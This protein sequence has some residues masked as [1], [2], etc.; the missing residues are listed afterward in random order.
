MV[1][2]DQAAFQKVYGSHQ[3]VAGNFA[4]GTALGNGGDRIKLEDAHNGTILDF[5]FDDD[6]PWPEL[7]DGNGFSLV[8]ISPETHPDPTNAAS[9][10][11]SSSKGGSPGS[12]DDSVFAGDP[13]A[14]LDG[15]GEFDLEDFAYGND[16]DRPQLR[17]VFRWESGVN[18]AEDH[19][20]LII[21]FNPM[22]E[23]YIIDP[24]FSSDLQSW[25]RG[26]DQLEKV[27]NE[28]LDDGR[29]LQI[30]KVNAPLRDQ[31]QLFMQLRITQP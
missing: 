6:A 20:L 18:G 24:Y 13:L 29:E 11:K 7:A 1:V 2:R 17:P 19:L 3:P 14:D 30:W 12:A 31:A 26:G 21:P 25:V 5:E 4:N 23:G 28:I 27:S 22:A 9:W 15:N 8:M 16:G 10:R